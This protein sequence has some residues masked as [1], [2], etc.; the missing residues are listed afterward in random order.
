MSSCIV[1]ISKVNVHV[2]VKNFGVKV[3]AYLKK[4]RTYLQSG[5]VFQVDIFESEGERRHEN[6]NDNSS[7]KIF[8]L[9]EIKRLQ[10]QFS[11]AFP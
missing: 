2:L 11:P 10:T 7:L 5:A 6:H 4:V 3:T 1:S 8:I 9:D